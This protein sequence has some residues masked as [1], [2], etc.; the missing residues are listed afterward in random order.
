[1]RFIKAID[2]KLYMPTAM[3][4]WTRIILHEAS[5]LPKV[6]GQLVEKL[7]A[8]QSSGVASNYHRMTEKSRSL[9]L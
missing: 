8:L 6:A 3:Q 1:M 2:S 4:C 9:D 5:D 7:S